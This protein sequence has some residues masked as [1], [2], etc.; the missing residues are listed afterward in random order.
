MGADSVSADLH[1]DWLQAA[2][3][4]LPSAEVTGVA[5]EYGTIDPVSVL[6]ALRADAWLHCHGDPTS[7]SAEEV[8][9]QLRAA[10]ADD[11]PAWFEAVRSRFEQVLAQTFTALSS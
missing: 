6:Q 1:G 3:A 8:R 10:F 5:I 9:A 7:P 11:D 4:M 2:P